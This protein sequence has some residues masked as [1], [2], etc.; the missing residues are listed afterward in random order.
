MIKSNN[1]D[2]VR[3][4]LEKIATIE[5]GLPPI[6]W[7]KYTPGTNQ[8]DGYSLPVEYNIEG[9]IYALPRVGIG[10]TVLREK[11]NG[12]KADGLFQTSTVTEVGT[13]YF[14]TKNSVYLY[15]KL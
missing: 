2:V 3:V 9:I 7:D 14:K 13:T 6:E 8:P 1:N 15:K 12:E 5:G 11:R 4:Y 10:F